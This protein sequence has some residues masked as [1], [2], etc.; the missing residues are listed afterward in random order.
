MLGFV[1]YQLWGTGLQTAAAQRDLDA[2]FSA[3][4]AETPAMSIA[5]TP[6]TTTAVSPTTTVASPASTTTVVENST[7]TTTTVAPAIW[8]ADAGIAIGDPIARIEMPAIGTD[9]IVVAG[10][11][12]DE[13]Q[14]G[15]GHFPDTPLPGQL[16][17]AAIAGHR[18]TYGQPFHDV[19]RLAEVTTS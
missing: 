11:G 12:V 8:P 3:L 17:N 9:H 15:P 16:G 5:D 1:A 6:T 10:V 2:R 19:D 7:T 13:L 18:T 14:Q 4:I